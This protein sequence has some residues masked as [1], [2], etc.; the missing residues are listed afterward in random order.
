[1]RVRARIPPSNA[2]IDA[3]EGPSRL[4]RESGSTWW[5]GMALQLRNVG[6]EPNLSKEERRDGKKTR[7]EKH[8]GTGD[9]K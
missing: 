6:R 2:L 8:G 9:L 7:E 5:H 3:F 1:M 4:R